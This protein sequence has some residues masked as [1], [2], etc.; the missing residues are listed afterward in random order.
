MVLN[1]GGFHKAKKLLIPRNIRLVF[2]PPYSPELNPDERLWLDLKDQ[3]AF[4]FYDNLAALRQEVRMAVTGY[5]DEAV[6]SLTG[7]DYLVDAVSAL[8]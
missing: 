4:D 5:T 8:S 6:A 3:V 1:N 7:Y 2:L